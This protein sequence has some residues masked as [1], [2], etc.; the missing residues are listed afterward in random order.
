MNK[1]LIPALAIAGL[2]LTACG[3]TAES[4]SDGGRTDAAKVFDRFNDLRGPE[5]QKELVAA[6]QKEGA[7]SVYTSNT[8]LE[9]IVEDFGDKYDID[10]DVYRGNS[11]SVV[12]R[13]LQESKS[14]YDGVDVVES[15]GADLVALHEEKLLYPYESDARAAVRP[16]GQKEDWTADFFLTYVA[17]WNT[18]L[19]K[20]GEEPTAFEDFADP[21]WKG[22]VSMEI[23]DS[24]WLAAMWDHY[25]DKGKTEAEIKEIFEAVAANAKVVKG[26][27]VQTEMLAAG[28]YDAGASLYMH[29]VQSGVDEGRPIAWRASSGKPVE[30][31]VLLPQGAGV[32]GT[33]PH[34]A[35]AAL[36]MDYLLT[37]GQK[38]LEAAN[39]TPAVTTAND[40]MSG[41]E[42]IAIDEDQLLDKGQVWLKRYESLLQNGAIDD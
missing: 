22:K 39:R 17:A 14:S 15:N 10:V 40:P 6:A 20:P 21:R 31:V 34:P 1:T 2:A 19:V 8:D 5:R 36:F 7:L 24:P 29:A 32:V 33:A 16:E 3:G 30:P 35:A 41:I 25:L 26:H 23:G 4:A 27:T 28:E 18:D 38:A 12:Q 13:I 37:E 9:A 11:E 42:T